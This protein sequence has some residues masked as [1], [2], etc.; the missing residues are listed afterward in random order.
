MN[1]RDRAQNRPVLEQ[2]PVEIILGEGVEIETSGNHVPEFP[3]VSTLRSSG[4]P[5]TIADLIAPMDMPASQS[6]LMPCL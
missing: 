2:P 3:Q 4:L 6:G 1:T 5:A